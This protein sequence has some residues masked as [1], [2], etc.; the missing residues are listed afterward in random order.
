[1]KVIKIK[2]SEPKTFFVTWTLHNF[3][4]FRCSY[5][6]SGL[7]EGTIRNVTFEHIK[8]FFTVL[9]S[10]LDPNQKIIIA[11]S[12]GEPTIIEQNYNMLQ[13]LIDSGRADSISLIFSTNMTNIQDRFVKIIEKFQKVTFLASCE[14]YGKTQEYLRFPA[15]WSVFEKNIKR[16]ADLDPSKIK[17]MCTPVI[18]SVNFDNIVEFFSWI[19]T[20][21]DKYGFQRI[22]I[23]PIVLNYPRYFDLEILP[24]KMK[25][26]SFLKLNSFVQRSE[27]LSNDVHF[28]G[29]MHVIRDKCNKESFN[30]QEHLKFKK[31][32]NILDNHRNQSL[33]NINQ[34]LFDLINFLN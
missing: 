11:F 25:Q 14:G 20:L 33:K 34:D 8:K 23:L 5:C 21:N 29:R 27:R 1:M 19:E 4:N 16:L 3:C 2:Q 26:T 10:K 28:M 13:D 12:G 18:Q 24:T 9:K 30:Y 7:N 22:Q 32:T 31:I 17:I 15:K 6:P